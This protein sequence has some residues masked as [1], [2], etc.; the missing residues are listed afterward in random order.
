MQLD[1][2]VRFWLK[3]PFFYN[4]FQGAIGGNA[5]RRSFIENHVRAKAGDKVIDIGCGPAE[6]LRWLPDVDYLGFDVNPACIATADGTHTGKGTFV[7]GDTTALWDDSRFKD[8]DIVI[9]LGILHHLEDD[10]AEH[11]I[12]FAHRALKP[13]GRFM[14][15]DACWVP[16]QKF[17]SRYIMSTDR[18][19]N[20]RTEQMYRQ[21]AGS[22]FT[23]VET[24]VD[25]KALRI[26]YVMIF[27]ECHK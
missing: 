26:P 13:G 15:F 2:G 24:W 10:E 19:Q 16:N 14:C 11:C 6:I 27:L 12:R 9:G 8:A 4:L 17:L 18:G 22:V 23:K 25:A 3:I 5:L 21:L 1:S 7:V 20:I